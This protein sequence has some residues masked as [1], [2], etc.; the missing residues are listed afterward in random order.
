MEDTQSI[1]AGE[2]RTKKEKV[3][4]MLSILASGLIFIGLAFFIVY[5]VNNSLKP[6]LMSSC[7]VADYQLNSVFAVD[8]SKLQEFDGFLSQSCFG[9]NELTIS[10]KAS[11][12][13]PV[14]FYRYEEVNGVIALNPELLLEGET[15]LRWEDLNEN[16][17]EGFMPSERRAYN[18]AL[19]IL[20]SLGF[21]IYIL[22]II[23]F[24]LFSHF[25]SLGHIRMN[26]IKIG[27]NQF[28]NLWEAANKLSKSIGMRTPPNIYVINGNGILNAFATKLIFK[29]VI[30]IYS[31]LAEALMESG[32][33]KQVE[34]VMAHEI[35]H[36]VLGHTRWINLLI[37]PAQFA[38]F[39]G[40]ALSRAREY[41][42]DRVML[43]LVPELKVGQKALIKLAGG[44][45]WGNMANV[46][47]FIKQGKEEKGFF[48][49]LSEVFSTHPH[50]VKR[51]HK[52]KM[53]SEK[54]A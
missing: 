46:D 31:D 7:F 28:T 53:W 25:L 11:F 47:I 8:R 15:C 22:A 41:S 26:G 27:H 38:P 24:I 14:C 1:K 18:I 13:E 3:Y 12:S 5:T 54:E 48:A 29:R 42:A 23:L 51:M 44:K 36:H 30:V 32:D 35:G 45:M 43:A 37:L 2:F 34:A 52:L 17:K 33:T 39:L 20:T 6:N 21:V 10:E 50:L 16:E 4:L 40:K 49:W 9:W 19:N